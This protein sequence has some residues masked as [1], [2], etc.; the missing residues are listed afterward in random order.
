MVQIIRSVCQ[1]CGSGYGSCGIDVHVEN[2]KVVKVEGTKGHPVN[3]GRL[4]AKGLASAQ[5]Q[6][7]PARLHTPLKRI[8]KRG[9]G[10]WQSLTWAEAMEIVSDRLREI[11]DKDG[12][13]AI[14][15]LKGQ[16]P[17]WETNW[18]YCQRFMNVIGSPN[19]ATTGHTCH[20]ARMLGQTHTYG[21]FALPD[22]KNTRCMIMWGA[23]PVN[24][25]M[26][27][28]AARILKAK[29][30]GA[31]LIVI[32]PRFTKT[33][34]K[35]DIY[36]QPRPGTDGALALSML[37]VIINE[38][39][40]DEEF[41]R[42]WTYGFEQLSELVQHYPPDK[43][44]KITWVPAD[45][46]REIAHI[47]ATI[48]PALIDE[49]NGIDQG[50]NVVQTARALAILRTITGNI[51]VPGGNFFHPEGGP[52]QRTNKMI[53]RDMS[54]KGMD[55]A[56]D[57]SVSKHKLKFRIEYCSV[58]EIMDAVL[59][60]EPYPLKAIIVHGMNPAVISSNTSRIRQALQKV[61]F[62]VVFDQVM[63]ATAELA[64][65]V[66]PAATFLERTLL[67]RFFGYS[68]PHPGTMYYQLA[69]KAVDPPVECRSDYDFIRELACKLGYGDAFPWE[70]VED[71]IDYEL[72]PIQLSFNEL[73][74]SSG[75]V[76]ERIYTPEELYRKY[77]KVF[78][79]RTLREKKA[80]LYSNAL[81][82]AG[83]D[84][85]PAYIEPGESPESR[86]DLLAK[87]PFVCTNIHK[88]GLFT[89][90]QFQSLPWLAEIISEP[91]IELHPDKAKELNIDDGDMVV[92][93]SLRGSIEIKCRVT[94]TTDPRVVAMTFGWGNTSAGKHLSSNMLTP[95]EVR[96]PVS[97]STSNKCFLVNVRKKSGAKA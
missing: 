91:W 62:L 40:Y 87:Y 55:E 3:D 32:D 2:N 60:G 90:T 63:T 11:I 92:V 17:G 12:T 93:E 8:G 30:N 67:M 26:A 27:N 96:C 53:M 42:K 48:K 23:N 52:F 35:A 22:Y 86:K 9:E 57:N 51:D 70:T 58:P 5:L 54:E 10:K 25:R 6:I 29:Q 65:I 39:L 15:W 79:A 94:P 46:I 31:K 43:V 95:H 85:L 36:V 16:G 88:P 64:D 71:A 74:S 50:P 45:T 80:A 34:A 82:E 24:S 84:P 68:N 75:P 44:E 83:Y 7:N 81:E 47:Y 89:H 20:M 33:A 21:A 59:T 66:L 28:G 19:L 37:N 49:T 38:K 4:C 69:N 1:M 13:R 76:I 41:V 56:F 78:S 97:D 14:S 18:D 73:S 61:D 72:K 77:D